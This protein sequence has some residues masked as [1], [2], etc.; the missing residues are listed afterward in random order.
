MD[1]VGYHITNEG[2]VTDRG[3][4]VKV[5]PFLGFLVD[6][7]PDCQKVL[8]DLDAAVASLSKLIELN[9]KEAEIL[10]KGKLYVSPYKLTYFPSHFFSVD[11]GGG[12]NH[13]YANFANMNQV[14]YHDA[15]YT[16]DNSIEDAIKKAKQA[17]D[18][19]I[20]VS[21]SFKY[22]GLSTDNIASPLSA[23]LKKYS[24]K[25][26]P[27][28]SDCP[29]KVA[30]L[31]W[32]AV[33]GQWF[34]GYVMG[35]AENCFDFDINGS[36][37]SE[38][39]QIPDIR[40]GSW[41]ESDSIPNAASLGIARV[42]LTIDSDFHPFIVRIGKE[43]NFTPIGTFE[44][45]L[46]LN[47]I[48]LLEKWKLGTYKILEGHWFVP[49]HRNNVISGN[50]YEG[51]MKW[52]WSK[53]INAT[54]RNKTIVTRVYS[55][56]WG[57]TLQTLSD[58]SFGDMFNPIV[59]YTVEENS[60]IKVADACLTE[61]IKPIAIMA[62]GFLTNKEIK[63][64]PLN[65]EL[66]GWKLSAKGKCIIAGSGA[67][68]F[69]G[70]NPPEGL[71]LRYDSLIEQIN[72]NPDATSYTRSK[73]SPVTLT[74]ALQYEENFVKLGQIE[75]IDRTLTIGEDTKRLYFDRPK[76]GR[77]LISGKIY[78]STAHDYKR[79]TSYTN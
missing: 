34:E 39:S 53:K 44:N 19:A 11:Y 51:T 38:M 43:S 5:P 76:T 72:E 37:C 18:T 49:M 36:Y 1:V 79:L 73:Y 57:R 50:P 21:K 32:E 54:A 4:V 47:A 16:E 45:I 65:S 70:D 20:E 9:P 41:V 59:G 22:L 15:Q 62:D 31:A 30:N 75:K 33:R 3:D 12:A 66:G 40:Y 68:C 42:S 8:Y 56:I 35:S 2:I 23:F 28:V 64:L 24:L 67:V 48:R 63:S 29:D 58:G 46:G 78:E 60:R 61:G 13:P 26:C 69:E 10:L 17:R 74:L 77:D 27:T 25:H 55:A 6:K 14:G 71:A 7:Y 52:L